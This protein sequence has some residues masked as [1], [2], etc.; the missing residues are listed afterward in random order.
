MAWLVSIIALGLCL[1]SLINQSRAGDESGKN[2]LE[3]VSLQNYPKALTMD[4][5]P[6]VYYRQTE[7]SD[8]NKIII[9][10]Q[11][12]GLCVPRIPGFEC[13][14]RC[15]DSPLLCTAHTDPFKNTDD[16]SYG[17]NVFSGDPNE[18]PTFHNFFKVWLPYSSSDVHAGTRGP[19]IV[20]KNYTFYGKYIFEAM[21]EDLIETSWITS[22]DQ[23]ILMGGSAGAIGTES[24]C[25][26]FAARLHEFNPGQDVRCISDSGTLYPYS[27]HTKNCFPDLLE[28]AAY[29]V[30]AAKSDESCEADNPIKLPCIS[31]GTAYMYADTPILALMSSEDTV[32]RTCYSNNETFWSEWRFELAAIA[33]QIVADRPDIGIYI[34]NCPFHVSTTYDPAWNSMELPVYNGNGTIMLK[35]LIHNFVN[36]A[37]PIHAIDDMETRNPE[38]TQRAEN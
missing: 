10:L 34:A 1:A 6:A 7:M 27:V 3:L 2:I 25:D 26:A 36:D 8:A 19:S 38:C 5:T 18:N 31:F 21:V 9:Y 12:G 17:D 37:G 20:T 35:E 32:I 22:A 13:E 23:V 29:Q 30:W 15:K 28:Y 14:S 11:G 4:G 33:E 16:M 24:N